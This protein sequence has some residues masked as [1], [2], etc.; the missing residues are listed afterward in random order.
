MIIELA[1]RLGYGQP[2]VVVMGRALYVGGGEVFFNVDLR[3]FLGDVFGGADT[4]TER[5]P[6][7]LGGL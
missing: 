6:N 1:W 5:F 3:L 4:T 2:M 7:D